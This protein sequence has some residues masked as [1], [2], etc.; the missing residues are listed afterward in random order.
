MTEQEHKKATM[1]KPTCDGKEVVIEGVTYVLK[2]K[3]ND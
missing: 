2:E 3:N 1:T